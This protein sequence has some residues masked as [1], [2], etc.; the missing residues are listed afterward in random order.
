MAELE[1]KPGTSQGMQVLLQQDTVNKAH[2]QSIADKYAILSKPS[3]P[4]SAFFHPT[5][6][7]AHHPVDALYENRE[8]RSVE[9]GS[10][11]PRC[12]N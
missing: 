12:V 2:A 11:N 8:K 3:E 9:S 4:A 7:S 10:P 5:V 1:S 6:D